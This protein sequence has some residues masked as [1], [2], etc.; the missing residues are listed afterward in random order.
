MAAPVIFN[1]RFFF[2]IWPENSRSYFHSP[3]LRFYSLHIEH[4][5]VVIN[6][7]MINRKS[8]PDLAKRRSCGKAKRPER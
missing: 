2:W 8:G 4:S 7:A 6:N 5:W 1:F 3:V